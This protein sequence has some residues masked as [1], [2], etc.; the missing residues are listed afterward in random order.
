VRSRE[1]EVLLDRHPESWALIALDES[2]TSVTSTALAQRLRDLEEGP[3]R[4]VSFAIGS[5]LGLHSSV[6]DHAQQVLSLSPMTLP[7]LLARLLLW[8][9]LYRATDILGSGRYHRTR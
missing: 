2:G 7:H 6:R 1:A 4:G 8:E 3:W 9:Q 5:D